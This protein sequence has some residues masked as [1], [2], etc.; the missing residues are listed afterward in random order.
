LER[1]V[2]SETAQA[3]KA[4][5]YM[6]IAPA[7]ILVVYYFVDPS[8]TIA[9]FT[10]FFGQFMLCIAVVLNVAAYVW[11]RLILTPDI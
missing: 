9:L 4:A 2:Q 10:T 6:A 8:N 1:K 11:A 3:R 7:V 5:V